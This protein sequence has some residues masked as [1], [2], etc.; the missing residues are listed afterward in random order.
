MKKT[1]PVKK[2]IVRRTG[3]TTQIVTTNSHIKV[4]VR[5]H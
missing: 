3:K 2:I 5:K 1:I 4:N